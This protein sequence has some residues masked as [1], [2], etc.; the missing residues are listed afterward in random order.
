METLVIVL[1][2]VVALS[3]ANVWLLRPKLATNWRGGNAT[4]MLEEFKVYALPSWLMF[5]VGV[6]KLLTAIALLI[7][8]SYPAFTKPAAFVMI[9]LMAC[10]VLMHVKVGDEARK[11][12]PALTLLALSGVIAGSII[13][14]VRFL[15]ERGWPFLPKLDEL[16]RRSHGTPMGDAA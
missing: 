3:I 16:A 13:E 6:A 8:L 2:I 5:T 10:A 1:Q 9:A 11:S 15:G 14:S 12:A 4:N 7:G